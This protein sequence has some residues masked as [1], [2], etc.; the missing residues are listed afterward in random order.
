V[1]ERIW[2]AGDDTAYRVARGGSWHDTPGVCRSAARLKVNANEGDE[3][4][5]FRVMLDPQCYTGQV[6]NG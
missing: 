2:L 1:D 4:I 6:E 3:M 5:G